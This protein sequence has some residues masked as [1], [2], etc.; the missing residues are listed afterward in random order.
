M[1]LTRLLQFLAIFAV[2]LSPLS[3][4]SAHAA[5]AMPVSTTPMADHMAD[6][7]PAGHCADMA[8][9]EDTGGQPAPNIDCLIAC[10]ALPSLAFEVEAHPLIPSF[11]EPAPLVAALRGLHPESDPPPPRLY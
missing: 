11:V 3:M 2:I 8:D 6:P 7:A 9:H 4:A 1:P 10:T 5:T